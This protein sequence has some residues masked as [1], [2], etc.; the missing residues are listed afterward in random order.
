MMPVTVRPGPPEGEAVS[1]ASRQRRHSVRPT[2][3]PGVAQAFELRAEVV[4]TA[5]RRDALDDALRLLAVWAVRTA[6]AHTAAQVHL[7]SSAL[8]SD[9]CTPYDGYG[10]DGA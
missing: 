10:E 9:E 5:G 6:R 3:P 7:D 2:A 1:D 8:G 4:P